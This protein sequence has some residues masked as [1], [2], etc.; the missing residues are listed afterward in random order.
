MLTEASGP[1]HLESQYHSL[2]NLF[3]P[4]IVVACHFNCYQSDTNEEGVLSCVLTERQHL[5]FILS[6]TLLRIT[7][8]QAGTQFRMISFVLC[9]LVHKMCLIVPIDST[10]AHSAQSTNNVFIKRGLG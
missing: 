8:C 1:A 9:Y 10:S 3:R 4:L 5:R 7:F 2:F 6:A